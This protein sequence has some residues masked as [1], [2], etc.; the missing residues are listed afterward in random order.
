MIS[1]HKTWMDAMNEVQ[2]AFPNAKSSPVCFKETAYS[3]WDENDNQ[4]GELLYDYSKPGGMFGYGYKIK[5]SV[6]VTKIKTVS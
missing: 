2:K 5:L 6:P 4:I 3:L 1:S